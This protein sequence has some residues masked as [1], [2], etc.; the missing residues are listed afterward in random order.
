ML[1]EAGVT[2]TLL[3]NADK[4]TN[5]QTLYINVNGNDKSQSGKIIVNVEDNVT[6]TIIENLSL[7]HILMTA[8]YI[9]R[10]KCFTFTH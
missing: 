1:F 4:E 5:G 10:R 6:F 3:V 7:I 8:Y 2:N 9:V